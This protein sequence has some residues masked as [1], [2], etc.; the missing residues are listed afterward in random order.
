[1][2]VLDVDFIRHQFPA[3]AHPETGRWVMAEN[4]GGAYAPS[5][6][7]DK[8]YHF[9]TATK[10]QPYW[11]SAPSAEA[12][13]AMDRSHAL[14]AEA[15]NAEPD[16]I[17]FG[18]STSMNTYVLAH[19]LRAELATGDEIIVT[20]QDHEANIGAWRRLADGNSGIVVREWGVDPETGRLDIKGLER[21]IN[22]RTRLVAVTQC[23]NIAGEIHDVKTLADLVHRAG[24]RIAVDAVSYAPHMIADVKALDVDFYYCSLYKVYGP[25]QGLMYVK[26]AHLERIANQGHGFNQALLGKRLTPAG[27]QHGEIAAASGIVDYLE[28]VGRHQGIRGATLGERTRATMELFHQHECTQA[29][30]ILALLSDKG[31][32]IIGPTQAEPHKRAAT[33]AFVPGRVS[34]A[35]LM[36]RLAAQRIAI[37]GGADFYARRLIEALGIDPEHGVARISLVHYNS[38]ADVDRILEALSDAL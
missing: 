27:P 30:R 22:A 1:M 5:H 36:E 33:I 23:S 15:F 29:N 12:G 21:L 16:E 38:A 18:P 7:V 9:M 6:V 10:V 3:F 35:A 8:L 28:D 19:A 24:A 17:M 2:R 11:A 37:G 20:N 4:A 13:R 14:L 32:R 34:P 31:A 26:R 25:H